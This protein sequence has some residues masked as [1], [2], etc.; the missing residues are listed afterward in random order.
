MWDVSPN[1][2]SPQI[3]AFHFACHQ[4]GKRDVGRLVILKVEDATKHAT[5]CASS[6]PGVAINQP[7]VDHVC[8]SIPTPAMHETLL[9]QA[10]L[11][12][13]RE[14]NRLGS[15]CPWGPCSPPSNA[16]RSGVSV[17]HRAS[18]GCLYC[19]A[20]TSR[21][22]NMRSRVWFA[23]CADR[24]AGRVAQGTARGNEPAAANRGRPFLS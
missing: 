21:P 2:V 10:K 15:R 17:E 5:K 16:D 22:M 9:I 12:L 14:V 7:S 3:H 11:A 20:E 4:A 8:N 13:F 19:I 6:C 18:F 1:N 24:R 23:S